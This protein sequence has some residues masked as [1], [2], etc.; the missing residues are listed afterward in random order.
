MTSGVN[1]RYGLVARIP[2]FHPGGSGSIPG[3]GIV[4]FFFSI[5]ESCYSEIFSFTL[6]ALDRAASSLQ[7]VVGHVLLSTSGFSHYAGNTLNVCFTPER[8]DEGMIL[9]W[10]DGWLGD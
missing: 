10:L 4:F 5:L 1:V 9:K 8:L 6:C 2:G 7:N 3:T